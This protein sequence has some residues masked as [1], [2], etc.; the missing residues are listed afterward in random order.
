MRDKRFEYITKGERVFTYDKTKV[1]ELQKPKELV[2]QYQ[3]EDL[4]TI[5][6][7]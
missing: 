4:K 6:D 5:Q 1:D 3:R 7:G 2:K